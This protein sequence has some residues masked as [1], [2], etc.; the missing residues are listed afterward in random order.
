MECSG[1][2]G[3]IIHASRIPLRSIQATPL[4]RPGSLKCTQLIDKKSNE[5]GSH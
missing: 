3:Y 4:Q 5:D 1:I 2:R